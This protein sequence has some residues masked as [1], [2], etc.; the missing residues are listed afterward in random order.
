M[1]SSVIY[2]NGIKVGSWTYG[3]NSF[4]VD[5][6]SEVANFGGENCFSVSMLIL[7]SM[8]PVGTP[9]LESIAKFRA[10]IL[11]SAHIGEWGCLCSYSRGE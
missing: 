3:Y 11:P 6:A 4:I 8:V 1:S 7:R 10:Q 2:L 9:E 5:D